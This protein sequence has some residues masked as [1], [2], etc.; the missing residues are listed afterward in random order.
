[1]QINGHDM[2]TR[3]KISLACIG[4][5]ALVE[6]VVG[7]VYFTASEVMPYHKEVLGVGWEQL[8]PGMRTML[9]AFVNAYGSGHF[10]V[11]VALA[12]LVMFP[13]RRGQAWARWAVLAV[14]LPMLGTTVYV[15]S[16]L[17]SQ[18]GAGTPWQGALLMLGVLIL[19]V[20]LFRPESAA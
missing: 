13:L 6:C 19:G 18:T 17:A 1:M 3:N 10:A 9:V 2:T 7:I 16:Y 5:V 12:A 4:L 11:G 20:A 15:A 8:D 14:G